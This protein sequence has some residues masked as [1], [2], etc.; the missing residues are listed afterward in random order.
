[1][2]SFLMAYT[3][4]NGVE[5]WNPH[6]RGRQEVILARSYSYNSDLVAKVKAGKV[7]GLD[8]DESPVPA[9]WRI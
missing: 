1:M 6:E 9:G 7:R 2:S 8:L 5:S 4:L 3:I